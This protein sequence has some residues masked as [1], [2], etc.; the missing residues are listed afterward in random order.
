MNPDTESKARHFLENET[1]FHLGILPTEQSN[2]KTAH[3]DAAFADSITSG[4]RCLQAVDRDIVPMAEAIF[5]SGEFAELTAAMTKALRNGGKIVFSGCGATGRLSIMLEACWRKFWR[6]LKKQKPEIPDDYEDRV[7]SI[8]TGGDYALVRSVENFE[9]YINFGRQQA[10][11]LNISQ[12]DCL[13]AITEGGETTSVLGTIEE[14]L[15]VSAKV[16]LLFNNPA[17]ILCKH[18]ERSRKAIENPDVTVL[19][20]YCGPMAVTG[21]T[22]MQATTSELLVAGV[23]LE[24]VLGNLPGMEMPPSAELFCR[25]LDGLETPGCIEAMAAFIEF[26]EMIYRKEG[27]VTYYANDLLLDIF[28]DTTE[29]APTFM[30]PPFR[31]CDD[32]ASLPSWAFVK[33]PLTGTP[34]TWRNVFCR[35][36]RCLAWNR[37]LYRKLDAAPQTAANPPALNVDELFKFRVGNEPDPSRLKSPSAAL[38][39]CLASETNTSPEFFSSYENAAKNYDFSKKIVIGSGA[40]D[41]GFPL[42]IPESP[43]KIMER[44]AV[45]LILNT[46]STGTMVRIGRVTGNWMSWVETSNKKLIDRS[47]RLISELANLDYREACYQ[48][49]ES[50]EELEKM[51]FTGKA[52]PSPAQYTIN[53]LKQKNHE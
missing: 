42:D 9:D 44:I 7:F 13:V 17:E 34:E 8:M 16:F 49:F 3:L 37:E 46:V 52:K 48:L 36:P 30:L 31:K 43:L 51:D 20:L 15:S 28:T 33:N 29:R 14:A 21:S 27:L 5:R 32:A 6:D 12:G 53:K 45:K 50:L 11:E 47:V 2:P 35:E 4:V 40:G 24:Q 1:Q 25:I 23:A 19:D 38:A 10:R 26:E 18:I 22:R 39:V 41:I